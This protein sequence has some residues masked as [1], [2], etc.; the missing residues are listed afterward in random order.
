MRKLTIIEHSAFESM[1]DK[2]SLVHLIA[3][4][5]V[6]RVS[7]LAMISA[8]DLHAPAISRPS[9]RFSRRD[10][11]ATHSLPLVPWHDR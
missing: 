4:G 11:R 1:F 9:K 7:I 10:E 3:E 2:A 5:A 8:R 6:K